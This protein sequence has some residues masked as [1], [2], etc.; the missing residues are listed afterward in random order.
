MIKFLYI[1]VFFI[2]T[3]CG[4]ID[5]VYKDNVNLVNPLYKKTKVT[6]SGKD[7]GFIN[8][9]LPMY[10]GSNPENDYKLMIDIKEE[11][12]NRSV[13]SNQATSNIRYELRFFYSLISSKKDCVVGE[14]EILSYF[15]II[16]KSEGYNYGADSSLENKYEL[17]INDNL[18][19]FVSFL[20]D[21]NVNICR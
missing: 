12:T 5:L 7:L 14:K 4:E 1:L 13:E 3:S 17:A 19:Q 6:T 2:V 18:N 21:I 8:S 10:F 15:S 16:P 20:S 9:Y 11:K